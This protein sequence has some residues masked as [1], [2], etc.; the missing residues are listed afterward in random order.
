MSAP[1]RN[2]RGYF[3]TFFLF[4]LAAGG[5]KKKE[6]KRFFGDTPSGSKVP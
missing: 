6:K 2:F 1:K 3:R 5:G 4:F